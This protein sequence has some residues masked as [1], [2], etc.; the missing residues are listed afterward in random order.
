MQFRRKCNLEGD[1]EG[2]RGRQENV[3]IVYTIRQTMLVQTSKVLSA[4]IKQC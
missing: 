3:S 4:N 2:E 1:W